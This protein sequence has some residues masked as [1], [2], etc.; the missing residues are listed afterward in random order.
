M[1]FLD[2]SGIDTDDAMLINIIYH[3][4]TRDT[5]W[6]DYLDIIYKEISTGEKRLYTIKEPEMEVY[7]VKDE[8]RDYT[9]N[10]EF[11]E[12]EKTYPLRVKCRNLEMGIAKEAGP[13]YV[14]MIKECKQTR[15][16]SSAKNIHKWR[17]VFGSDYE[18]E[19]YFRIQWALEYENDKPK[20]ITKQ[21]ADIEVDSIDVVGFPKHGMCPINAI[22]MVD[23]ESSSCYTFLLRCEKNPQIA[24][25]EEHVD[26]FIDE[27]HEM[28]DDSYGELSYNIYMY[29]EDKE[30][31]L[32]RD[33][34]KLINTL[35]RDFM[36]FWNQSFD[37]NYFIDRIQVLGYDPKD[38]M[39]SPDF[40]IK[41]CYYY[42]DA[43]I[44]DIKKKK[45]YL[46]VSAYTNYIDQMIL[47]VK[48]RSGKG[49]MR[50]HAL[51]YVGLA[52]LKDEKLDYSDE[53]NIK[54]LPYVNYRKF[55]KYNLKDCLLQ[56]GIEKKV[57]DLETLYSR[58]MKNPT[59]CHKSFSQSVMLKS[60][61]YIEYIK[62]G[63]I[64]GNNI[65][66]DYG[67]LYQQEIDV[68]N[69]NDEEDEK[70]EKFDGAFS[71]TDALKVL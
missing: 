33:F 30:I 42:P 26:D 2:G 13:N 17:Y 65:N 47:Y 28:F 1:R 21:Y 50:S 11:I 70:E 14:Q 7:I 64:I 59:Q 66:L 38:I 67:N 37:I 69:E 39:T 27:L 18:I 35:K 62:Q 49:E 46:K 12:I 56:Y 52:E 63:Y 55:V 60:R 44:F 48:L 68:E 43:K 6:I 29:D 25:F 31:N 45:D 15:N 16:W 40:K 24:E 41:E 22:T 34:F 10:K 57:N 36:M 61:T 71:K 3:K 32:I 23:H 19:N 51:N 4:P 53:A 20:H 54:T 58:V 5:D 9:Y 8:Y